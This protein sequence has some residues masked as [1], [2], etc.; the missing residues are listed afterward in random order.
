MTPADKQPDELKGGK[1]PAL[2]RVER[3]RRSL[4]R[5][6]PRPKSAVVAQFQS[7]AIEVEERAPPRVA[8]LTLYSVVALIVAAVTWASVSHVDMIVTA[9]G[10]LITT[11][12]NLVVQPLETS[13]IRE[14][15]VRAGD[16]VNRGDV[17]ATLDP[18]FSQ[19]DLDQLR[20]RVAAFD[21]T[22][23]RLKAE[24]GGYEF[25]VTDSENPDD[26]LQGKMFV[27]RRT[28]HETQLR[29]F[30]AQIASARANLKTSQDEE[31]VLVQRLETMKSIEAMRGTLMDKEVGSRLNFLLSR[32]AR[33][34][35]ESTLSKIRGNQADYEHKVDKARADQQVFVE[36]FRRTAYQELVETLAKRNSAAEEL[37]KVEL[38]RQLIMLS[39]P[40]DAIVLEIANRTIGSVVR[41]AETLFVLV[42]RDVP[43][44]AEINVEG[45][46]IGQ[47]AVGQSVRIKFEAFPFQKYGT[48]TGAVR[49]VSQ[50]TFAPDTKGEATHRA[51]APY[52][53]V[54]VD[55][56]DTKLRLQPERI[57][58]IPGMAVT[59]E[60]KAGRRSVISYFLYPLLRG[61][62]E[63]IREY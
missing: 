26:V 5:S 30:D 60:L 25:V 22:I 45:K 3:R 37:K 2:R 48:G 18:T 49:V 10:K 6:A 41:E 59:A 61:L 33:L 31:A 46:D 8:R 35:V 47:V 15:H 7:D 34:D 24:L 20:T 55:V 1:A 51:P 16:V 27:Q 42:P 63:S 28:F 4:F 19:A 11:R 44:Q 56:I 52:Y 13:V 57:Q 58:M 39:A 40:A 53:R 29:N 14:I 36:E 32:D 23:N 43:L 54:L 21:A 17:L 62:D 50:D 12:P 9:Q 38:R